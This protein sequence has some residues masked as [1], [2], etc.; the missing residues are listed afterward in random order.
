MPT[1]ESMGVLHVS[2]LRFSFPEVVHVELNVFGFTCLWKE[3]KLECLKK[4]GRT[5]CSNLSSL[6]IKKESPSSLQQMAS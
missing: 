5:Y 2:V 6:A 1:E 3:V 4:I